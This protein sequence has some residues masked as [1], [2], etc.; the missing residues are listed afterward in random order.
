MKIF[1]LTAHPI[2]II[3]EADC[4]SNPAIRKL[5]AAADVKPVT[6]IPSYGMASAHHATKLVRTIDGIP[7]YEKTVNTIDE[8]PES[9]D[10]DTIYIVSALY[11]SAYK[12]MYPD[13][14][15]GLYTV[16]DPVYTEDGRTILG[17]RGIM[18]AF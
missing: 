1:N 18:K 6:T 3:A 2:N 13:S 10:P 16:A 7:I 4:R 11:V 5:V 14:T 8:L 9:D 12:S 15:V 17:S